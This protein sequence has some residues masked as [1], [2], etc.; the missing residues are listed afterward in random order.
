M[1]YFPLVWAGLWRKRARTILTLLSVIVA[2][3]LFGLLQGINASFGTVVE[4]QRGN[5]LYVLSRVSL[6]ESLPFAYAEQL[7]NIPGVSV[8]TYQ[9]YFG[10]YFQEPKNTIASLAI[11][12]A[13]YFQVFGEIDIAPETVKAMTELRTGA[14]VGTALAAKN[15]WKVG[16][17]VPMGTYVYQ[18]ADGAK[19]W[20]V[21]IVGTFSSKVKPAYDNMFFLGR[22][23]FNETRALINGKN[24]VGYY[25]LN[26]ADVAQSA[27]I[28]KTIDAMFANS[29]NETRTY[30]EKEVA[31]MQV[32]SIGD[33]NF[34]ITTIVGGVF[35]TLLFLTGNTMAQS[36]RERVPELAVMKTLGFSDGGVL[37]MVLAEALLLCLIAAAVGMGLSS[38]VFP[39]IQAQFAFVKLSGDVVVLGFA[40]AV[41]LALISGL[42]PAW[43]ARRLQIIE[44]LAEK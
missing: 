34:F 35:F 25:V 40:I 14:V 28:A 36:V 6:I 13:T 44:A 22:E 21:D 18:R 42:P 20:P 9:D 23:Y 38:L 31:V 32:K 19:D 16:D 2:F 27:A 39:A 5:R 17:R 11:D 24:Q 29:P 12:P 7:R 37:A 1:K 10:G 41:L 43:R 4:Q 26:V 3:L 15:G 8:V 33:I 30:T